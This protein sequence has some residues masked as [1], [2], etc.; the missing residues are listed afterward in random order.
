MPLVVTIIVFD[1]VV[2]SYVVVCVVEIAIDFVALTLVAIVVSAGGIGSDSVKL[3]P[4]FLLILGVTVVV[5]AKTKV[6]QN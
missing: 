6:L 3:P 1:G 4:S 2:S 5:V